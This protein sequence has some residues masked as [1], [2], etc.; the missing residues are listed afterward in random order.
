MWAVGRR[1]RNKL[2]HMLHG[3]GGPP[4]QRAGR[5]PREGRALQDLQPVGKLRAAGWRIPE[6]VADCY[7][8]RVYDT[9][10]DQD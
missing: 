10:I 4:W 8:L 6:S 5:D 1:L 2:M 3:N 7:L 9:R